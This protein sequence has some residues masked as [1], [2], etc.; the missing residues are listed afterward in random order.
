MK[1]Y[2]T[3]IVS[4][5]VSFL[6]WVVVNLNGEFE[7]N[8]KS[9]IVIKNLS[10]DKAI[11]NDYP[12]FVN[13]RIRG[14]GWKLLPFYFITSPQVIVDLENVVNKN[15]N[16]NLTNNSRVKFLIPKDVRIVR[17]EPETLSFEIDKK[18]SKKVPVVFNYE[19]KRENH[20]LV[21]LPK[22]TPDSVIVSGA[23]SIV[24]KINS[25]S[26]EKFLIQKSGQNIKVKLSLVNPDHKLVK[27]SD[28]FVEVSFSVEQLVEREFTVPVQVTDLP[29][30]KEVILFPPDVK[31]VIR[32]GLSKIVEI[33]S[34]SYLRDTLIKAFVSYRDVIEDKTGLVKPHVIIPE[35]FKL[36]S[37]SPEGLEYIIRQK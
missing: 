13:L 26:T 21:Q 31:V 7:D 23:E 37:V 30:D 10:P 18:I 24:S 20:D 4:I 2:V 28:D 11:R 33:S 1:N 3:F 27:L 6:F 35:N 34:E 12:E 17:V 32:G 36:V 22:I 19:I 9:K 5:F 25:I 29:I 16:V 8:F 15:F 14:Q